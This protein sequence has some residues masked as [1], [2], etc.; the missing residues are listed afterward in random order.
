MSHLQK[1]LTATVHDE[2]QTLELLDKTFNKHFY[3][4]TKENHG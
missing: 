2:A 4:G 3:A 1:K